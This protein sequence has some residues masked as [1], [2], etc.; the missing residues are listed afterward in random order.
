MVAPVLSCVLRRAKYG[1]D[2][3]ANFLLPADSY[4]LAR[5]QSNIYGEKGPRRR[6]PVTTE[7]VVSK[8]R[9]AAWTYPNH[10]LLREMLDVL[11]EATQKIVM[12]PP[13]HHFRH[14]VPGSLAAAQW[15]ECRKRITKIAGS[16]A[17]ALVL[18]FMIPSEITLRDENYWD[19][20]HYTVE[21]A[22]RLAALIGRAATEKSGVPGLFHLLE[23]GPSR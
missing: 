16:A 5:A 15:E 17:N 8:A 19:D 21:V 11:P 2:G 20:I 4:D 9:R 22:D 1:R 6:E 10:S 7:G 14:P 18:D 13:Y 3:Y 23:V 12:F